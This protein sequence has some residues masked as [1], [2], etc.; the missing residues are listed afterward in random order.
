MDSQTGWLPSETAADPA[1]RH[2]RSRC[3]AS[4]RQV[5][6]NAGFLAYDSHVLGSTS[7]TVNPSNNQRCRRPE[8][9]GAGCDDSFT[10]PIY[11]RGDQGG[12]A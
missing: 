1:D 9:S 11:A 12:H 8:A 3:H 5:S 4:G 6:T 2:N 10:R 7:P